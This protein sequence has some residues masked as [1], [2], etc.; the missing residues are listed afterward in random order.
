VSA[1]AAL[2]LASVLT[3]GDV[4]DARACTPLA[5]GGWAAATGAGLVLVEPDG[6]STK[7]MTALDGLPETRV[8]AVVEQGD[9]V[10]IGTEAGAA[11][12]AQ[13]K[14]ARTALSAPVSTI[15][16]SSGGAVW[17]GTR[18][19]GV[20]RL[21]A[22]DAAPVLVPSTATGTRTTAITETDGVVYVAYA[23]GPV[24]RL[25]NGT[26][27][28]LAG[29][30]THGQAI[31]AA[32]GAVFV[33][34]LAGL[35]RFDEKGFTS[36]GSVD[37]RSIATNASTLLV[38]TYGG[39]VMSG[40]I[41]GAL[42]TESGAAREVR[43]VGA[44][45]S[46][47]CAATTSGLF[48]DAGTGSFAKV[49]VG[50]ALPS[51]DVTAIGADASGKRV[52]VGT[53]DHGAS[54]VVDGVPMR[55][56]GIE[57]SETINGLGWNGDKLWLATAHGL[58]RVNADGTGARRFTSADGL[59]STFTRAVA[60]I[61]ANKILVGTESGPAIV[62]GDRITP[63]V[64]HDKTKGP[65]PIASPMHATWAVA[66]RADGTMFIGT[67]AGLYWGKD[68]R[69]E[70]ASLASGHLEDDWITAL[71]LDGANDVFV[72]TYS[73]GVTRLHFDASKKEPSATHLGG[74]YVNPDGLVIRGGELYA[75]TM[76]H[77]LARSKSDD[78]SSWTQK[79]EGATG[80]DVTAVRFI[81]A[82][83]W[84]A[85]RRGIAVSP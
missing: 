48:V 24:A 51:N 35:Y 74:G 64:F 33:G 23:D 36:I 55:I 34:D 39:G 12:V 5:N 72:G 73:K 38:G 60:T 21:A 27:K 43:G 75:A 47:R 82:E 85:S 16:V 77:L 13:G 25:E 20:Y 8:H 61:D 78:A 80:R 76:E 56:A 2:A 9:G 1:L 17:L 58:Y 28:P 54:I 22:K 46:A 68:G 63:V 50:P 67:A 32:A 62:E 70:R 29:S 65:S 44:R 26:L 81:G 53:F 84:V 14:V 6:K 10:W 52:A 19:Q 66:V 59:P 4:D 57:R 40:A 15:H 49:N 37:A 42:H 83:R 79:K 41:R 30:P 18:G 45:G 7:T 71:A 3:L 11:Y 31:A 69:F